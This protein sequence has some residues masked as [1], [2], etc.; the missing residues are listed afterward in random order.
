K[1]GGSLAMWFGYAIIVGIFSAYVA[2]RAL[3]PGAHYL[4]VF[5]FAG[6][7]AF[8]GYGLALLQN[9]I[10]YKWKWSATLASVGDALIY[11]LV[12]AGTFGW[13]WPG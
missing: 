11:A 9:S 10:W 8:A 13:L 2:G 3:A 5:R 7:V 12:T 6:V 4:S 1:M